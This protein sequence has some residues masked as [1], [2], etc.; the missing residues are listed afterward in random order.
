MI[1]LHRDAWLLDH[2][3][4]AHKQKPMGHHICFVERRTPLLL[5]MAPRLKIKLNANYSTDEIPNSSD[6]NMYTL[7][8]LRNGTLDIL[9]PFSKFC[10]DF[11]QSVLPSQMVV[12]GFSS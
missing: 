1:T 4:R 7:F 3:F 6:A 9:S 12:Q 5:Y 8:S 10:I 11:E 2:L